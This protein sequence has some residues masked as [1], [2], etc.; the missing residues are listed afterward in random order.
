[1]KREL[2]KCNYCEIQKFNS[3]TQEFINLPFHISN[4]DNLLILKK[5]PKH[6]TNVA[7]NNNLIDD[8]IVEC[9][10]CNGRFTKEQ[11]NHHKNHYG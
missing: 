2:F 8:L 11:Y 4:I 7:R 6:N 1:M 5:R 9:K 10:H 3:E